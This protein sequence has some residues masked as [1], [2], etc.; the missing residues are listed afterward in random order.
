[1]QC[2]DLKQLGTKCGGHGKSCEEVSRHR[3]L[4]DLPWA[5]GGV[6]AEGCIPIF[7]VCLRDFVIVCVLE[8]AGH[9]VETG[10]SG[11]KSSSPLVTLALTLCGAEWVCEEAIGSHGVV[12]RLG[13]LLP[14]GMDETHELCV[15]VRVRQTDTNVCSGVSLWGRPAWKE[16]SSRQILSTGGDAP[17]KQSHRVD[18]YKGP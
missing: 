16:P 1:M 7:V 9:G 3:R 13:E 11:G 4:Y 17:K 2:G 14:A 12:Y 18:H 8:I 10:S 15:S 5:T 6:T